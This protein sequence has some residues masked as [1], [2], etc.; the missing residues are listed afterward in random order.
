MRT[1][2]SERSIGEPVL[3]VDL[4]EAL[5]ALKA[6]EAWRT[7]PRSAVTLVKEQ[8]FRVVLVGLHRGAAI[9]AHRAEG[10]ISIHLLEGS[11]R[12]AVKGEEIALSPGQVLAL[13]AGLEHALHADEESAFLLTIGA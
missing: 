7:R 6:E 12:V 4:A 8:G 11:V 10:P 5:R 9:D 1:R 13:G 2:G 3:K